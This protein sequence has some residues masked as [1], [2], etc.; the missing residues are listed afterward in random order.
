MN[1]CCFY[2][3][4]QA[5]AEMM[6]FRHQNQIIHFAS[7]FRPVIKQDIEQV[8]NLHP[9]SDIE[10]WGLSFSEETRNNHPKIKFKTCPP[11]PPFKLTYKWINGVFTIT[12]IHFTSLHNNLPLP[13]ND[14]KT[15][16][17]SIRFTYSLKT[18]K[19]FIASEKFRISTCY[20]CE[21]FPEFQT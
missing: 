9:N 13:V 6:M 17:K 8:L 3:A 11:S 15:L 2:Q 21:S 10:I 19:I 18:S 16:I 4:H 20:E 12:D 1:I 14:W 5:M 7:L